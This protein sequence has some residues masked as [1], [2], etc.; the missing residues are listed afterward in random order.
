D[1]LIDARIINPIDGSDVFPPE[2]GVIGSEAR[3]LLELGLEPRHL[4]AVKLAVERESELLRQLVDP[5]TRANNA[6]A[7]ERARDVLTLS[8]DSVQAMHR[9][10]LNGELRRYL[11]S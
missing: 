4:R 2:T 6:E 7:Q 11:T 5:L 1:Q 3:R 10:M 9:A 8:N